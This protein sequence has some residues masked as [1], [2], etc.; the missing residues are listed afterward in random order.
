[1]TVRLQPE[2]D[3]LKV[4]MQIASRELILPRRAA[5]DQTAELEDALSLGARRSRCGR[6]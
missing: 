6:P 3:G 4:A 1:M 2:V 5:P